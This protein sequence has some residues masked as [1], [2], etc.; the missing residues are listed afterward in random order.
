MILEPLRDSLSKTRP[1]PGSGQR[2]RVRT[3]ARE[4][5]RCA[6][7]NT[8]MPLAMLY[9]RPERY[10]EPVL[11][12]CSFDATY[13]ESLCAGDRP[14]QEHF[15]GYFT[16]LLQLKLRSRLQSPQAVE[17]VRQETFARVLKALRNPGT[18]RQPERLGAFVNTVCNNVLFE[19][20]RASSRSQSLDEEGQPE[21]PATGADALE[22]AAAKQM[23]IKVR[24]ILL[25]MPQRDR[26][27]L[28]AVFLDERDRDDV[29]REFGVEREY[30]RVLLHRAKQE[31]KVEYLKRMGNQ[32]PLV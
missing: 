14:T 18:L 17:D 19:H 1:G 30:L 13:I 10:A 12:F 27:L 9:L 4:R 28:K 2:R 26:Q 8:A 11:E 22:I 3:A 31:F 21:L 7:P 32:A 24:E 23:K 25:E 15:V 6:P 16:T 29:C 5:E 20:Y